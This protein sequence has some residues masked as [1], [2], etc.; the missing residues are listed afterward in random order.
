[1][2]DDGVSTAFPSVSFME[3]REREVFPFDVSSLAFFLFES[4]ALFSSVEVGCSKTFLLIFVEGVSS[5]VLSFVEKELSSS[6]AT[7]VLWVPGRAF[8]IFSFLSEAI[9]TS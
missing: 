3:G 8:P 2:T 4:E 5:S 9:K 1:M 7:S 6:P